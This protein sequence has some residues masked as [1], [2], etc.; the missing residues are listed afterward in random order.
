MRNMWKWAIFGAAGFIIVSV[1]T[2]IALPHQMPCGPRAYVLATLKQKHNETPTQTG[3]ANE[4]LIEMTESEEGS[5]SLISTTAKGE[6][7]IIASGVEW[8]RTALPGEDA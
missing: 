3:R 5:W 7:C 4:N 2:E 1:V 6:T 8:E